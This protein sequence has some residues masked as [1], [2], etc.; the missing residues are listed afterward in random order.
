MIQVA[1]TRSR[2][3]VTTYSHAY[4]EYNNLISIDDAMNLDS[5]TYYRYI[6]KEVELINNFNGNKK[7]CYW[8]CKP[9]Q[10]VTING[11]KHAYSENKES[12]SF[13]H[14]SAK[15][16]V[17]INKYF[18]YKSN[19]VIIINPVEEKRIEGSLFVSDVKASLPDG[20]NCIIEIIKTSDLSDEKLE[21]LS[22]NQILTFKIY[23]DEYGNQEHQR[24]S[25]VGNK[26]LAEIE[27]R[28]RDGEGKLAELRE[29][30]ETAR[31][32][33]KDQVLERVSIC[34]E[35]LIDRA[36]R[37][38]NEIESIKREFESITKGNSSEVDALERRI[39]FTSNQI[40]A[41]NERIGRVRA[42]CENTEQEIEDI[43][44]KIRWI[45]RRKSKF[46][47]Y[48]SVIRRKIK[49]IEEQ[50]ASI[51]NQFNALAENC[52]IEWFRNKWITA[53]VQNKIQ[54]IKYWTT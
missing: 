20:T 42:E 10:Y 30:S 1:K 26:D 19:K 44:N 12:E 24:D 28:I 43:E 15:A 5:R 49:S 23:I 32:E 6:N 31:K 8:S 33:G 21:H 47:D 9:N 4:D 29:Q 35:Y 22:S 27:K 48:E 46:D 52:S 51:T 7:G 17:I 50:S 45:N 54:E 18:T 53:P 38:R 39:R 14:K 13:E 34:K 36:D 2:A 11:T 41:F 40:T 37:I 3:K 25:I 16:K